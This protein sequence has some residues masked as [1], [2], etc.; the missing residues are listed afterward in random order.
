MNTPENTKALAKKCRKCGVEKSMS[1][2]YKD[3]RFSGG[4]DIHCSDCRKKKTNEWRKSHPERAKEIGRNSRRRNP[5]KSRARARAWYASNKGKALA[6]MALRRKNNPDAIR[7]EKLRSNFGITLDQYNTISAEQNHACAICG[8]PQSEQLKKMAVDH[9]HE[10]G[11]IRSL[12][13]H[14]CNV[15]LGNFKDSPEILTKAI[16][17]IHE[18]SRKQ[19][20]PEGVRTSIR[21]VSTSSDGEQVER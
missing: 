11:R 2:Y 20:T 9:D 15:G 19:I 6:S 16:R 7:N 21:P 14:N 4:I 18:H 1:S 5:E 17:Y 3:A 8:T 13:C 12:L 10:T